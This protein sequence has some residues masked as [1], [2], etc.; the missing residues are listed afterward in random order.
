MIFVFVFVF[1][2]EL[3]RSLAIDVIIYSF[4]MKL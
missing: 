1:V 4:V 3:V 2:G